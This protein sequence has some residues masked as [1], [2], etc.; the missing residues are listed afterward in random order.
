MKKNISIC[1][2]KLICRHLNTSNDSE[3]ELFCL[4]YKSSCKSDDKSTNLPRILCTNLMT[5]SI[6]LSWKGFSEV[7]NDPQRLEY[8][9]GSVYL[10]S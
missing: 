10:I 3:F 7:V 5:D 1:S 6:H 9:K 8:F 4:E 2:F